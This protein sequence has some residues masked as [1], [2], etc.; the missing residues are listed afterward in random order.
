MAA[1]TQWLKLTH[2]TDEEYRATARVPGDMLRAFG[3]IQTGDTGQID[4]ATVL[5]P[6]GATNATQSQGYEIFRMADALQATAPLFLKVEP[7]GA[8]GYAG[9]FGWLLTLGTGTNGAGALTGAGHRTPLQHGSSGPNGGTPDTSGRYK[10]LFSGDVNRFGMSVGVNTGSNTGHLYANVERV[11]E[12]NGADTSGGGTLLAQSPSSYGQTF[13]Q[14][15]TPSAVGVLETLGFGCVFPGANP[16]TAASGNNVS[17]YPVYPFHVAML[18]PLRG[19]AVVPSGDL[20]LDNAVVGSIY[21]IPQTYY[22]H[23]GARCRHPAR[24]AAPSASLLFR[25]E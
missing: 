6:A 8:S 17:L 3:W 14:T 24:N 13:H 10:C 23:D 5:R 22:V 25:Y 21:G 16:V 15:V 19:L 4:W 9:G 1:Q 12:A 2:A 7:G 20:P 18:N 11:H